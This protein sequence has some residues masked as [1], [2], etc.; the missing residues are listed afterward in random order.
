MFYVHYRLQ[1]YGFYPNY[2][3]FLRVVFL[4]GR[5]IRKALKIIWLTIV[6]IT[7]IVI[8]GMLIV[9]LPQ[10]Q[11]FA[12]KKAVEAVSDK[13][14][15][16][17]EFEKIHF[18]PFTTLV[19]KNIAIIDR[20]PAADAADPDSP[21]VDTLFKARYIIAR[22]TL[23]GLRNAGGLHLGKAYI[24]DAQMNLVLEDKPDM[25]DGD[26][27]TD[28]LSRIFRLKKSEKSKDS[29]RELFHI[30]KVEIHNFGFS[31]K[32]HMSDKTPYYGGINWNDLD[33]KDIHL[34]AK[35]LQFK[36]GIMSGTADKLSF[37][38]KS[39]YRVQAMSGSA[40]VGRG[41]TII[42]EL[43]I[44]DPWSNIYLPEFMMSYSCVD[45]FS[46]FISKVKI[47][48][49]IDPS[50]LDFKT[51]TYFAPQLEGN[52][53]TARLHGKVSGYVDD[54]SIEDLWV[55]SEAGGF[56]G[57]ASGRM[58]GIPEIMDTRIDASL[59]DFTLTTEGLGTFLSE[60]TE[61]DV[62]LK[63]Y[64]PQV[65]F[66][67]QAHA[68]GPLN[69]L[70]VRADIKTAEHGAADLAVKV[71]E[72]L[73]ASRPITV[74]G[75]VNTADLDIGSFIGTDLIRQ[76]TMHSALSAKLPTKDT[77]VN[78]RIDTLNVSRANILDYDYSRLKGSGTIT[79]S[80]FDGFVTC[81]DPNLNFQF[82][83][84]FAL[85][86]KTNDAKYIFEAALGYA[87]LNALN[88]DRRGR[89]VVSIKR[90]KADF[91]RK[92]T[93]DIFGTVNLADL[94]LQNAKDRNNIGNISIASHNNDDGYKM[95]FTSS[96]AEASYKGTAS[97]ID[98]AKDIQGVTLRKELPAIFTDSTY[99]WSGNRY[100]I[101]MKCHNSQD[102]MNFL[103]PGLYIE[104]GTYFK[105]DID[106][107][108]LFNADFDSRR[109]AYGT[110]YLKGLSGSLSNQDNHLAGSIRSDEM[111]VA[112]L[113]MSD[114]SITVD[115]DD[116][117]V[118]LQLG[119]D[120]HSRLD[121]RGV[122]ILDG[123]LERD[124]S[125][126]GLD[127]AIKPSS[128][129]IN[130]K[131]WEIRPSEIS[132]KGGEISV[133][134][135][136]LESG[137]EA[138][139][140]YGGYS[141]TQKDTL[142]LALERFDVSI[143]NS[144]LTGDF[145]I[146][147]AA[148]GYVNVTSPGSRTGI[149][150]DMVC[151]STYLAGEPLGTILIGSEWNEKSQ[152][153]DINA[154]N[155]LNGRSGLALTAG[156]RPKGR[157]LNATAILDGLDISYAQPFLS[158]VF[159]VMDGQISGKITAD[160]P[161]SELS[162]GS[163]GARLDDAMLRVAFTNVPYM[164]DGTLH[165]DDTGVYFDDIS[166]RDRYNGTGKVSGGIKYDHFRN[167][168]F[169]TVLTVDQIEAV[170][171]SEADSEDFY[172]NIFATGK[173][174][175]K[176]P[177][178]SI[179]MDVDA[180]TAKR[181]ELHIPMNASSSAGTNNL[182]KFKEPEVTVE[183]DPYDAFVRKKERNRETGSEFRVNMKV[184][185]QP[186]VEAF[187]EIDKASGNVLSGKGSGLLNLTVSDDVFDVS[188]DYTLNSGNYK[189]VAGGLI[190]R[191]F[192][193]QDGSS[194]KFN[195][196]IMDSDLDIEAIYRTKAA[197]G[198][199]ISDTTSVSTRRAVECKI[200]ISGRLSA[201]QLSFDIDVPDLDP[202]TQSRVESALSTDDK[203][204]KQFLSLIL[205]NSFLPDEQSGIVNNST[206]LYS[207][208]MEMMSNQL[209]NIFQKLGIPI[210]MGLNYQPSEKGNDLFDVA[211][212][213][214]L[215]NNRVV[216]NGSVGNKQYS[217]S[218]T[219]SDVVGDLDIE[220]KLNRSGSFRLNLF[221]HSADS[222]TNYLD[223]SQRSGGGFTYQ[224]EFN[225]LGQFFKNMF[226][227]KKRQEA[228]QRE[229]DEMLNA[230]R[231]TLQVTAP[232]PDSGSD[233][234]K[235]DRKKVKQKKDRKYDRK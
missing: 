155:D 22:F 70:N 78:V 185:A 204:Q 176:G 111:Q 96:F 184:N 12:V 177:L 3:L 53:L 123:D 61:E 74:S 52:G 79:D 107:N 195:G 133:D 26:T 207:N 127:M 87:N 15:G 145:G 147:G 178:N 235:A 191:D 189:F 84:Q 106:R 39:G 51:L 142:T 81:T 139:R 41:K 8:G 201:P 63:K 125:G 183:V 119:Y 108:G 181:G 226:S 146:G 99:V 44:R 175:I 112:T 129:F 174:T 228:R 149:L 17:I 34:N 19:V 182:L 9:Q 215:F 173:V 138:V 42:G 221:S 105:A 101:E 217:S 120:N 156:Y 67:V 232:E 65:Q 202:T 69:N 14:D 76:V 188:G 102:L 97:I 216:V 214:Q 158:D 157:N 38:E 37:K 16:D 206:L 154:R 21:P 162:I 6:A 28:N 196:D 91:N 71:D 1:K 212:S 213:T 73:T 5:I 31:M 92:A 136:A 64:I 47:D 45:D 66:G 131:Q 211:V 128:V 86:Q 160:G 209:N 231:V 180:V 143:L 77:P 200:M 121:N 229:E 88:L 55:S 170:N 208:V 104:E 85:S 116:N 32:N 103:A 46:D 210:D 172:G 30:R 169:N 54:F 100:S 62:D 179:Q 27:T 11:T 230:E 25:G 140:V 72:I 233:D 186:D 168:R 117:H 94:Q 130:S 109:L 225:H 159:S 115:A 198:T 29:D 24:E 134:S 95:T 124:A 98:F 135:F 10:V 222:Y 80:K 132:I 36:G 7:A 163:D 192:T 166:V 141:R 122:F 40:R 18:K 197:I 165:L 126:L 220:I 56:E 82:K 190:G 194:I 148:T 59:K 150:V 218:G 75:V 193:I 187:V 171:L 234:G 90:V 153:F 152:M 57:T 223:N 43:R 4:T 151:D 161:L 48:A 20:E 33:I 113:V 83:G 224:A 199:L 167:F 219:Q 49:E 137:D 50:R 35:E 89:S 23:E 164:A 203:I 227:K 114:N 68:H 60:W 2:L 58:K 13:L 118:E 144:V 93:G 110:Q 205:S